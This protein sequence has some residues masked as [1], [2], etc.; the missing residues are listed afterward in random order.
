M[1]LVSISSLPKLAHSHDGYRI[2]HSIPSGGGS[3]T[4][5][6]PLATGNLDS[7]GVCV[8]LL[9]DRRFSIDEL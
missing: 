9:T 7:R 6:A 1:N 2:A 5:I 4:A 8:S 3:S